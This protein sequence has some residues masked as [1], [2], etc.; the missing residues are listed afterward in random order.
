MKVNKPYLL[1]EGNKEKG[2]K[3]ALPSPLQFSPLAKKKRES[4]R[5]STT[6]K[7]NL[8][9]LLGAWPTCLAGHK[10]IPA[11]HSLQ[12]LHACPFSPRLL[13]QNERIISH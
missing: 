13:Y 12:K 3:I 10:I 6:F 7:K 9:K 11:I 5:W 2:T 1:D 8:I 4:C